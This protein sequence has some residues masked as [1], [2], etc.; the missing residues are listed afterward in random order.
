[1]VE[2]STFE[3]T[4]LLAVFIDYGGDNPVRIGDKLLQGGDNLSYRGDNDHGAGDNK[5]L[6]SI[7]KIL[8]QNKP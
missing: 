4:P 8:S 7:I 6:P 1:L 5:S 2:N 3:K